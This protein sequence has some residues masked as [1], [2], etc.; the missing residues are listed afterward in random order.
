MSS[1]VWAPCPRCTSKRVK[2]LERTFGKWIGL[3]LLGTVSLGLVGIFFPLLWLAVPFVWGGSFL[4]A[5]FARGRSWQCQ[6]CEYAWASW[7]EV[8]D[9]PDP[10]AKRSGR[11][12]LPGHHR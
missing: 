1:S 11:R 6:D 5:I 10:P 4:A 12:R 8:A 9:E 7:P 2:M 3:G